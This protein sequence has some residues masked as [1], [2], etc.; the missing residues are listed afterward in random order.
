MAR[1]HVEP[2]DLREFAS[3]IR[4]YLDIIESETN[5]LKIQ[6]DRLEWDD[7]KTKQFEEKLEDLLRML[8]FFREGAEEQIPYLIRQAETLE[9]YLGR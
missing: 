6:F 1:V 5:S 8:E 7:P 2:E 3:G 9:E 4:K